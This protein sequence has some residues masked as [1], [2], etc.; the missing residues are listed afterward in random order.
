MGMFDALGKMLVAGMTGDAQ[1]FEEAMRDTPAS[2]S[3]EVTP[4]AAGCGAQLTTVDGEAHVCVRHTDKGKCTFE[5]ET[6]R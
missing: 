5:P 2:A 6:K 1:L 4:S 3:S